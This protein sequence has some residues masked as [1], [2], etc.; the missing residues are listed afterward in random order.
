MFASEARTGWPRPGVPAYE[1]DECAGCTYLGPFGDEQFF[2]GDLWF[3]TQG[4]SV[5]TFICR[6]DNNPEDYVSGLSAA[7]AGLPWAVEARARAVRK[8]LL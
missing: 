6:F 7:S 4:G 1:H 5:P 3:C 2:V 8:G